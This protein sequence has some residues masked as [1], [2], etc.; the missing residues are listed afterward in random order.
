MV[1]LILE[2]NPSY[3]RGNLDDLNSVQAFLHAPPCP[4]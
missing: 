3:K 4:P 2:W 1:N